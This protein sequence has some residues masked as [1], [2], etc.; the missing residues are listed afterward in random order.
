[1]KKNLNLKKPY[2]LGIRLM[3]GDVKKTLT[4]FIHAKITLLVQTRSKSIRDFQC[5]KISNPFSS[6]LLHIF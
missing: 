1:M 4:R 2:L 3:E 5:L 6:I